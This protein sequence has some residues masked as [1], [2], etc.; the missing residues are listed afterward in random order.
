M[1]VGLL[2]GCAVGAGVL[3]CVSPWLWPRTAQRPER[4]P[5]KLA[6]RIRDRMAQAGLGHVPVFAV[7][8]VS[9]LAGLMLAAVAA[10][11]T[12]IIALAPIAF[13]AGVALPV[14]GLQWRARSKRNRMATVWPEVIDH[15]T[16][17]VRSGLAIPEALVQVA[18]AGPEAVRS[19]FRAFAADY[20]ST[21]RF[22]YSVD[23]LKAALADPVADRILET[24]RMARQ[25]G[26][27]EVGSV[28]RQL[29]SYLRVEHAI[30]G[31]VVARQSWIVYAARLG[32][33]APWL[34]LLALS[35]RPE[36][37]QAYNTPG[38]MAVILCGAVVTLIA[39]RI[40]IAIGRLPED[41]RSFA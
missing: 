34:V 31:E 3:L 32:L 7:V 15:I 11:L 1:G 33:V 28:L 12:G 23:R 39:Y 37:A 14:V 38:G 19:E 5:S 27:G 41:E 2:L 16:A 8:L 10:L 17:G 4:R 25:V 18:T 36:A 40:M 35:F 9:L 22:E 13:A 24:L 20:R 21:G 29:G 30:R 6:V 26:G